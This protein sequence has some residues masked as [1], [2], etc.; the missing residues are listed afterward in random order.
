MND[1]YTSPRAARKI[2]LS[3]RPATASSPRI[4]QI[5]HIGSTP[6]VGAERG[7]RPGAVGEQRD[8]QHHQQR[9]VQ[10]HVDRRAGGAL[11]QRHP[12]RPWWQPNGVGP[13]PVKDRPQRREEP[14]VQRPEA[15]AETDD[16]EQHRVEHD[17]LEHDRFGPPLP[18]VGE[19]VDACGGEREQPAAEDVEQDLDDV[20]QV[21]DD[22]RAEADLGPV[23]GHRADLLGAGSL[24][25]TRRSRRRAYRA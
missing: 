9:A 24:D 16:L 21:H 17:L 6:I 15:A 7:N 25:S 14:V 8:E 1:P 2:T 5:C 3:R 13:Q 10:H 22:R 11:R 19:T 18:D 20:E 12:V 4:V 23:P